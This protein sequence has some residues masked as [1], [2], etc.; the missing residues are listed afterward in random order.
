MDKTFAEKELLRSKTQL[1][2]NLRQEQDD[3]LAELEKQYPDGY[4][5]DI[6]RMA[7][8]TQLLKKKYHTLLGQ[9]YLK[10]GLDFFSDKSH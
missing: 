1:F 10:Y 6:L 9:T 2:F 3:F 8:K 5:D 7:M 4:S